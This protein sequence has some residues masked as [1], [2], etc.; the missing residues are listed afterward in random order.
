M[1]LTQILT[2]GTETGLTAA[3]KI[4]ATMTE[5][6][7]FVDA[8]TVV[9]KGGVD[10]DTLTDVGLFFVD[11]PN[12]PL[13]TTSGVLEV[14]LDEA[15]GHIIQTFQ[16]RS[17]TSYI[18]AHAGVSWGA[19]GQTETSNMLGLLMNMVVGK[20]NK[21]S[22]PTLYSGEAVPLDTLGK[23]Y[24]RYHQYEVGSAIITDL[25]D[26][27]CRKS[28]TPLSVLLTLAADVMG[29]SPQNNI[30]IIELNPRQHNVYIDLNN[31]ATLPIEEVTLEITHSGDAPVSVLLTVEANTAG[32]FTG[33][34]DAMYDSLIEGIIGQDD[35]PTGYTSFKVIAKEGIPTPQQH[36]YEKHNGHWERQDFLTEDRINELIREYNTIVIQDLADPKKPTRAEALT[37]FKTLPHYNWANNDTFY[38]RDSGGGNKIVLCTYIADGAVDEATAGP[39]F[40]KDMNECV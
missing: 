15:T 14:R 25:Y 13:H 28:Y 33:S 8:Y 27:P 22:L 40:F 37:A 4:N 10:L 3:N 21:T 34:Y 17:Y 26:S 5:V 36:D 11:G 6:D 16:S 1:A 20:A 19:W 9:D 30:N 12:I 38:I 31:N 18:R 2:D 29:D 7:A 35:S 39:I 23:N 32:A 24:D